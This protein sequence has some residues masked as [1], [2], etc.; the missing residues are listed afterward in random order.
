MKQ[1]PGSH[2]LVGWVLTGS[3]PPPLT[4]PSTGKAGL[5]PRLHLTTD[6]DSGNLMIPALKQWFGGY[7]EYLYGV[8]W[9]EGSPLKSHK[10]RIWLGVLDR[11]HLSK[12]SSALP[13]IGDREGPACVLLSREDGRNRLEGRE[14]LSLSTLELHTRLA[15][16]SLAECLNTHFRFQQNFRGVCADSLVHEVSKGIVLESQQG[17]LYLSK[18]ALPLSQEMALSSCQREHKV[19][20]YLTE[21]GLVGGLDWGYAWSH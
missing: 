5:G 7:R 18:Q 11:L 3:P 8:C 15:R 19:S 10:R 14:N 12:A 2:K 6:E 1:L 21:H 9:S 17:T 13:M 20:P 4:V 16:L